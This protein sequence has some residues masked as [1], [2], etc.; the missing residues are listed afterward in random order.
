[1]SNKK[2]FKMDMKE[3]DLRQ[4]AFRLLVTGQFPEGMTEQVFEVAK[5][6]VKELNNLEVVIKFDDLGERKMR[7]KYDCILDDKKTEKLFIPKGKLE[8]MVIRMIADNNI[9]EIDKK[10]NPM[11]FRR[12][13]QLL[14]KVVI[15]YRAFEK[16]ILDER[17][18]NNEVDLELLETFYNV[19]LSPIQEI[20]YYI[21][22]KDKQ[23]KR[24]ERWE[25]IKKKIKNF[26]NGLRIN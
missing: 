18:E 15:R 6:T 25:E 13:R 16:W 26:F 2:V 9:V 8:E 24:L 17:K 20:S 23:Y 11:E 5:E 12:E 7:L 3:G 10:A 21:D 22:I 4:Y 1:M 14:N 19:M